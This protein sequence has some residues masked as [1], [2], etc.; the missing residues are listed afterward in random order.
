VPQQQQYQTPE[1]QR[2]Q[3]DL[4]QQLLQSSSTMRLHLD[5]AWS[6]S[7]NQ[8]GSRSAANSTRL[9][10]QE[11]AA[12]QHLSPG[13]LAAELAADS[14]Q[15]VKFL[16]AVA[17]H[18]SSDAA[19]ALAVVQAMPSSAQAGPC[20]T[21]VSRASVCQLGLAGRCVFG[22]RGVSVCMCVRVFGGGYWKGGNMQP[23]GTKGRTA[24][25]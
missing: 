21:G 22:I 12:A 1:P 10:G 11:G 7:L 6:N 9:Q 24:L 25:Q 20:T 23:K 18:G 16:Q 14:S 13:A 17:Q 19:V 3:P 8:H 5:A 4:Q 2:P 15:L